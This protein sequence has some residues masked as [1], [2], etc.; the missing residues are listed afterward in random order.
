MIIKTGGAAEKI[1]KYALK[2]VPSEPDPQ[3]YDYPIKHG[4]VSIHRRTGECTYLKS[5]GTR[6]GAKYIALRGQPEEFHKHRD[7][8]TELFEES[9]II[10]WTEVK[11]MIEWAPR[12][13]Q[14]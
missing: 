7:T 9:A 10:N 1:V 5:Q 3:V 2:Y 12:V 11:E 14:L 13:P 4:V 8:I 6:K